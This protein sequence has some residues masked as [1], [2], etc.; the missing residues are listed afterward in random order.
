MTPPAPQAVDSYTLLDVATRNT[1]ENCWTTINGKV[2]DLT[3]WIAEHPGGERAI[4]SLC[5]KDGT[6]AFMGQ[7]GG[8]ARAGDTLAEF[9]VGT[10][11]E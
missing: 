9:Q 7:H 1:P 8:S 4:L 10:L 6:E 5:G 3:V 11:V 2:Y